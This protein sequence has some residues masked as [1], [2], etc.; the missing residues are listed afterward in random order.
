MKILIV[1]QY[2]WPENFKI[3]DLAVGFKKKGNNV[4]VLTGKPNYP[5]GKFFKGYSFFGKSNEFYND[6]LINRVPV[7]P[8]RNGN[9]F[10]LTLNYLSFIFFSFFYILFKRNKYDIIFFYSTSPMTSAF[11]ALLA[12]YIYNSKLYIWVQD[13]WPESAYVNDR[14]KNKFL[15]YIL[16]KVI[17]IIYKK[18]NKIFIQAESMRAPI[19]KK[20]GNFFKKTNIIYLPN[21]AEDFYYKKVIN[22]SKYIDLIPSDKF[23]VLFAGN[24]GSGIDVPSIIKTIDILKHKIKIQFVFIGEGSEKNNFQNRINKL[25]INHNVIF[26]KRHEAKEM[27]FF[28]KKADLLF[29][30]LK[31]DKIYSYTLP[32]KIPTYMASGKPIIVMADG[33]SSMTIKNAKCGIAVPSGDYIS[34]AKS[35][36]KLS[37]LSKKELNNLGKNGKDF[38]KI[39]FNKRKIIDMIFEKRDK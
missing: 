20:L 33:E 38:S 19:I 8:R 6:I 14:I 2:F 16:N 36:E 1:S 10:N 22:K 35:I 17:T 9:N 28:F 3:N 39:N 12:K 37:L 24:I 4:E 11:P 25:K 31:N 26:L 5:S 29:T 7:I 23:T 15:K 18:S 32:S 34:L 27:P 21:W 13:L 30:S